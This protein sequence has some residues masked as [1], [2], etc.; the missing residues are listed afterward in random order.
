M[1]AALDAMAEIV[2]I[3]AVIHGDP[4]GADRFA[5]GWARL[6]GIEEIPFPAD[7]AAHGRAAGPIRNKRMLDEGRPDLVVAF[8]GGRGTANMVQQA[9]DPG[10]PVQEVPPAGWP[11]SAAGRLAALRAS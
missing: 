8:P 10:L 9:M 11:A 5:G 2:W 7:W 3:D 4:L 1:H 6:R